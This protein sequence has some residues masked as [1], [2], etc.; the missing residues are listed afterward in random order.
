[1]LWNKQRARE[2]G[3]S[4]WQESQVGIWA[5]V[6]MAMG[7]QC[8]WQGRE[9]QDGQPVWWVVGARAEECGRRRARALLATAE[10]LAF[11]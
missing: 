11:P 10:R 5:R 6:P 4:R 9:Q 8:A 3:L 2:L 7:P 1:M